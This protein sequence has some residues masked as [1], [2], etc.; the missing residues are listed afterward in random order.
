MYVCIFLQLCSEM[1]KKESY[2]CA[3]LQSCVTTQFIIGHHSVFIGILVILMAERSVCVRERQG[4]FQLLSASSFSIA[5]RRKHLSSA[6]TRE[7]TR[8]CFFGSVEVHL[9]PC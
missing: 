6:E 4:D 1:G 3:L 9:L 2:V 5:Q 8:H 7:D